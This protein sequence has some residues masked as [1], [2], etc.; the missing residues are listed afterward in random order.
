MREDVLPTS[1]GLIGEVNGVRRLMVAGMVVLLK[2]LANRMDVRVLLPIG[3]E[4]E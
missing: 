1:E 4:A 3:I 2:V